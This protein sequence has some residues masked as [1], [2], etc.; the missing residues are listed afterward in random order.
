MQY[1][2]KKVTVIGLGKTGLS[3]VDFLRAKQADVRVIDTRQHPAG[4]EQLDKAIPLHTG[5]LNQQWLLENDLIVI[6]PGLAVKTPE[7]QTAL[8]AGVEVVGD[9]ELFCRE[10]D[11]PIV[12][13]TGSNGKST[14]TTLVAEMAKAAGLRVGMG[15]NIGIPALSLLN[16][17]HDLYV[18]ELSSFQL[19]TTYSLKAVA[20]TVLNV[21]EDH[22]NRYVDLQ[23]YRHA[24]LNIYN[25]CQTAV[26]NAEDALTLPTTQRPQ[27]QVS[28]GENHA[29]YW[30]KTENNKTYLM[31]YDEAVLA[32]DE[33]KLTGRHNYMNA[34]AAI[35]LAQAAGINLTGIRTALCAFGGLEHRFQVAH[36]ADGVRW[37]NDS[38]ATNVGSTVAALTGLQ[39]AGKLHL[40]LGGDGKGADFSELA[41]LI[42]QPH[43]Y[44]YCF[45]RDGKQLAAL[46]SQSQLFDTMEHAIA[47]IRPQLQAGDMVLLSPACAS[48]DQFSCFE[49]RG[50]EFTRLSRLS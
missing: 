6:S 39:V 25:H 17:Q 41:R 31:A 19:E 37:I 18:L 10:A 50:D 11:K 43:I 12:A 48:L 27:K 5:G 34:L 3:S 28:F 7:I 32:C 44:C 20:A 8:Q 16:Q 9:I 30:L 47:A 49:A 21:T 40:L 33:M 38:K 45:G 23:D 36:I 4:A 14:V 13:I 24:K 22:M 1:Q 46:S 15:G 42:N 2:D 26:I 35:A 29:D